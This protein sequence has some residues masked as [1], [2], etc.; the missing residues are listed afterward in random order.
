MRETIS[1]ADEASSPKRD[2]LM[3]DYRIEI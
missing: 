3:R 2:G 1:S